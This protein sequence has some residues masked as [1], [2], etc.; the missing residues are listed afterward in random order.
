ME[1]AGVHKKDILFEAME[2][3]ARD[4][5]VHQGTSDRPARRGG[6]VQCVLSNPSRIQLP[7]DREHRV[8][9]RCDPPAAFGKARVIARYFRAHSFD[10]TYASITTA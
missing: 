1:L 2:G 8:D 4:E 7:S 10:S 5:G 9:A 6:D 3:D